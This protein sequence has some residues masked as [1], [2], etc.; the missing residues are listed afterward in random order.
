M[1]LTIQKKIS[2][3]P[4]K[5]KQLLAIDEHYRQLNKQQE[6]NLINE[7]FSTVRKFR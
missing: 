5:P 7:G 4:G 6:G 2:V 3:E 1:I